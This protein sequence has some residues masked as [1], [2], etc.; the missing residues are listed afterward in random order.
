MQERTSRAKTLA[1]AGI[2]GPVWFT[3]WVVVQ[4]F[5]V[6][7]TGFH[8]RDD[9]RKVVHEGVVRLGAQGRDAGTQVAATAAQRDER[10]NGWRSETHD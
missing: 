7:E 4:G 3:T 5:L 9:G 8:R 2:I 6:P 10:G 1:L